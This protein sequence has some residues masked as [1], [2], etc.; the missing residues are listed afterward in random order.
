MVVPARTDVRRSGGRARAGGEFD[1]L[2]EDGYSGVYAKK[3]FEF[4]IPPLEGIFAP[5]PFA[6]L[7]NKFNRP[8]LTFNVTRYTL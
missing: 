4:P 2:C 8:T 1:R 7:R 6:P 5:G 3:W